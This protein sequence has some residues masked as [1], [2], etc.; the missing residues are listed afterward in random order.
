M[1]LARK[2]AIAASPEAPAVSD[3]FTESIAT[4]SSRSLTQG[5]V[6][7]R[8]VSWATEDTDNTEKTEVTGTPRHTGRHDN[9]ENTD[10]ND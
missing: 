6:I 4:S 1:C 9:T 5:S 3:G 8:K 2:A 7:V 10:S